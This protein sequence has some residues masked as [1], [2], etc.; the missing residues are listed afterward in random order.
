MNRK[1][2]AKINLALDITG[3]QENGY[4]TVDMIM[5]TINLHDDLEISLNDTG[6]INL[7]VT[8]D[9]AVR[10]ELTEQGT[11][12][13]NLAYRAATAFFKELE[14]KKDGSRFV[15]TGA[16][17]AGVGIAGAG[18][19]IKLHKRIPS[20]AGLGGGSSDAAEVLKGLNELTGSLLT[21]EE[22]KDIAA[23]LG[24]DVPF[25]ISGGTARCTGTGTDIEKLRPIG[26]MFYV[27]IAK[28]FTG[29]PTPLIYREYDNAAAGSKAKDFE[30]PDIDALSSAVNGISSNK[31]DRTAYK[32]PAFAGAGSSETSVLTEI[33][34][35]NNINVLEKADERISYSITKEI[36]MEL[37][38]LGAITSCM[39]G[40]GSAV[41]GLFT[42]KEK[43]EAAAR[44]LRESDLK[45]RLK[46]VIKTVTC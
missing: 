10:G 17:A 2:Y 46:A 7:A 9:G 22:L 29:N 15:G 43:M 40:S 30:R 12:R 21:E 32:T 6:R 4:H 19:D 34:L 14:N 41:Y 11:D 26:D 37:L 33:L 39:S 28:P 24:S 13:D 25:F 16:G 8:C 44:G 20:G 18:A 27:V 23:K 42:D 1:A 35:Q 3:I 36:K 38:K 45:D 5:Q 31:T